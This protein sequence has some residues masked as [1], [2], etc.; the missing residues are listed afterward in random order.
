MGWPSFRRQTDIGFRGPR[1]M[2]RGPSSLLLPPNVARLAQNVRFNEGLVQR[3]PG[4][5]RLLGISAYASGALTFPGNTGTYVTIPDNAVLDLGVKWAIA[6]HFK[7]TGTPGGTQYIYSRDVTPTTAGKKTFALT[8]SS[9]LQLGFQCF[10]GGTDYSLAPAAGT[11][12]PAATKVTILV[13]RNGATL[14]MYLNGSSIAT[15]SDLPATT[16]NNAGVEALY[17]A[18]NYDG[19]TRTGAFDGTIGWF[20]VF[21]DYASVAQ[22]IKYTTYQPYPNAKDPRVSLYFAWS[23]SI[24]GTG[25][26]VYDL[27]TTGNNGT[28]TG[29]PPRPASIAEAPITKVQ[30]LFTFKDPTTGVVKV[31]ALV[32][33][34]FYSGTVRTS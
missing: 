15:R 34:D 22:L 8:V 33:G 26:T 1:G 29:A 23:Y 13:V 3:R 11:T 21:R 9:S 6:I 12:I 18:Q 30:A 10:V 7:T 20:G 19:T 28:I 27:S 24:E 2:L 17:I 31:G 16:V 25:T 4:A 32:G 14:T 5:V